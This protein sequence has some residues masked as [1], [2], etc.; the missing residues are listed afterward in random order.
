MTEIVT[1]VPQTL[2]VTLQTSSGTAVN[3]NSPA[4][5]SARVTIITL[6]RTSI[7]VAEQTITSSTPG[8]VWATGVVAVPL[9]AVQSAALV[10][11]SQ[12]QAEVKVLFADS[13]LGFWPRL[14]QPIN[15]TRGTIP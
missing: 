15:V 13:S 4:A 11:Q 3:L 5:T 9:T 14:T 12:V 10:G 8:S 6:D 2:L 7:L 1:G